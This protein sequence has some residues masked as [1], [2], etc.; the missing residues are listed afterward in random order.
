[1]SIKVKATERGW[2]GNRIREIGDEFEIADEKAFSKKWMVRVDKPAAAP[3]P[4]KP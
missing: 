3:A 2:L 4:A 1:M